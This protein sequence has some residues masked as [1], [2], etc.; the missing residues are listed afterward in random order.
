MADKRQH[1]A[2]PPQW[3]STPLPEAS[4]HQYPTEFKEQNVEGAG[5]ARN[6]N[7]YPYRGSEAGD[8]REEQQHQASY[9]GTKENGI[10]GELTA[11]QTAEEVSAR[12]VQ[13]VTAEA[14]AVLKGEQE[15]GSVPRAQPKELPLAEDSAN[16]PPSPPPSPAS[17]Q[18]GLVEE[19]K[20]VEDTVG[21]L[22][23]CPSSEPATN[24]ERRKLLAPSISVS[25][26][27][28]DPYN[29]DDEYY[30]HPLFSSEWTDSSTLPSTTAQRAD[31]LL[32]PDEVEETVEVPGVQEEKPTAL[33]EKEQSEDYGSAKPLEK[34]GGLSKVQVDH[35]LEALSH[36]E[37][38]PT[39]APNT[40]GVEVGEK[41]SLEET[42]PSASSGD[43]LA[44]E[45]MDVKDQLEMGTYSSLLSTG[46]PLDQRELE[47][48]LTEAPKQD[49]SASRIAEKE[50]VKKGSAP[51]E[52]T[53]KPQ[54]DSDKDLEPFLKSVPP[55]DQLDHMEE[56][57]TSV[58]E[59]TKFDESASPPKI[60]HESSVPIKTVT[61]QPLASERSSTV[62]KD[63]KK[64]PQTTLAAGISKAGTQQDERPFIS[65]I[66]II[67]E[68]QDVNI[69]SVSQSRS[70]AG[71][72]PQPKEV[73]KV[74]EKMQGSTEAPVTKD[75]IVDAKTDITVCTSPISE[76]KD[77][78]AKKDIVVKQDEIALSETVQQSVDIQSAKETDS[79]PVLPAK[80]EKNGSA[81]EK[82]EEG[83][84]SCS[85]GQKTELVEE[86]THYAKHESQMH[87]IADAETVQESTS[88]HRGT[89]YTEKGPAKVEVQEFK[90][91]T[92]MT[93]LAT[94]SLNGKISNDCLPA[95]TKQEPHDEIQVSKTQGEILGTE[96]K[97]KEKE[98]TQEVSIVK[99]VTEKGSGSEK[100]T[101]VESC[102]VE[103]VE[104]LAQEERGDK[105]GMSAYF[106]TTVLKESVTKSDVQQGS[107]YYELSN[108]KETTHEPCQAISVSSDED[109]Q[110][111]PSKDDV[112]IVTS[113]E[114]NYST[115]V[116]TFVSEEIKAPVTSAEYTLPSICHQKKDMQIHSKNKDDSH[117][118]LGRSLGLGGRSAIEQRSM[119]I[120]L[121]AS[122]LDSL[123][124]GLGR[125]HVTAL[126][127]LDPDSLTFTGGSVDETA[128]Y[129]PVT[130]PSVEMPPC[131]PIDVKQDETA[132]DV[133]K[134]P[135]QS[136]STG[137]PCESPFLAKD[138]YRNGTIVVPDLPEMLD[139]AGTRSRLASVSTDTD[140]AR[141]K[142]VPTS[143]DVT[144]TKP[145]LTDSSQ[146]VTEKES[147]TEDIGYCVFN[148]YAPAIPVPE[149]VKSPV[150]GD[151]DTTH[152]T[153]ATH[154]SSNK[155]LEKGKKDGPDD[156]ES[157]TEAHTE[158]EKETQKTMDT[159]TV[160]SQKIIDPLQS[161]V[162]ELEKDKVPNTQF[163]MEIK[164]NGASEKEQVKTKET[165]PQECT[166]GEV[167]L[168]VTI[169][170]TSD[171]TKKEETTK[172]KEVESE[173]Q[174]KQDSLHI[175]GEKQID[176]GTVETSLTEKI[177]PQQVT[178]I[179]SVTDKEAPEGKLDLRHHDLDSKHDI[180]VK[181]VKQAS[182]SKVRP[183]E[184]ITL[185]SI[186]K[187][188]DLSTVAG[189][190]APD[191][192]QVAKETDMVPCFEKELQKVTEE[193]SSELEPTGVKEIVKQSE[194][195]MK[196][197]TAKPDLVHQEAVDKEESYESSGEHEH[198]QE[199]LEV[200][201]DDA[202]SEEVAKEIKEQTLELTSKVDQKVLTDVISEKDNE[203]EEI[204]SELFGDAAVT[205]E[206]SLQKDS[207]L[208]SETVVT[209]EVTGPQ[210]ERDSV[211]LSEAVVV[212]EIAALEEHRI[213]ERDTQESPVDYVAESDHK[214][215]EPPSLFPPSKDDIQ[216]ESCEKP[217]EVNH[218]AEETEESPEAVTKPVEGAELLTAPAL[219]EFAEEAQPKQEVHKTDKETEQVLDTAV[220]ME[221]ET[222]ILSEKK[223]EEDI[224]EKACAP[225]GVVE[226]IVTIEDD[227]ITV[228]QTAVDEGVSHSIRFATPRDS[229]DDEGVH[230]PEEQADEAEETDVQAEPEKMPSE[231]PME[232]EETQVV[233][234]R[235]QT[236]DDYKDETTIDD[237]IMD[238][239]SLWVDTQDD[240]RSIMT[241]QLETI[242]K[243]ETPKKEIRRPSLDKHK[244]EKALKSGRDKISTPERK[245]AK[246]EPSTVSKDETRRKKAVY[247][248]AELGKKSEIQTHSPS[249]KIILK[250]AVRYPRPAHHS[251]AKRK[252]TAVDGAPRQTPSAVTAAKDKIAT[253]PSLTKIPTSKARAACV[254]P[255][256]PSS[257]CFV[258]KKAPSPDAEFYAVEPSNAGPRDDMIIEQC[259]KKDGTTRS[260]EKRSSLPRP[261]SILTSR[262]A[263]PTERDENSISMS[264]SSSSAPKRPTWTESSR[265]RTAKSGTST[266]TTPGSTAITPS[267]PPSYSSRTPG[268][269]GTP[270]YSRTPRTPGTPK[271]SILV[272]TEKKVAIIRTPPKSPATPKQLKVINQPLP[273]L[274]NIRS[275][276]GSIENIKYQP[277]GGQVQIVTKKIDLSHITSKCGSLSNIHHRPGG[278]NVKIE[279]VKLDFKEKAHAKVGSLDNAHHTPGGG[280]IKIESQKLSFR[281]QAKARVDHGAEIVT[282]SPNRSSVASPRRLS[283]VSSSGSIN[284]LESP[285]LATLA[286][287]VTA[288]LAK[289][290]L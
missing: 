288:A 56:A 205:K 67:Y 183:S 186:E 76:T 210:M 91:D 72:A 231:A 129:L 189:P 196:E 77:E 12:I 256:R 98:L 239:D 113:L 100:K 182:P 63:E 173:V 11:G 177:M 277:K 43:L 209:K 26:P 81:A 262:R 152:Q 117:L 278:G 144:H 214:L 243:E 139:L 252:Q 126:S 284:L 281:E 251:S 124:L 74:E 69:N 151:K 253:S 261:S 153:S 103:K 149:E 27:D 128:D 167:M 90:K 181:E 164:Y 246:K 227:F 54:H 97:I 94:G 105:S 80:V 86:T 110:I 51:A 35:S 188:T 121:P 6:E 15:K 62:K 266:P 222:H 48:K 180:A 136:V 194:S 140:I 118:Y 21:P 264:T 198:I 247:K 39:E 158:E 232:K 102:T 119:S 283:N 157:K 229:D 219:T 143:E 190:A 70:A 16:L 154:I 133:A 141:R 174:L 234:D 237:S 24:R 245:I 172:D 64:V 1:E 276:I 18:T 250:P 130:T 125:S 7:G 79:V 220:G 78:I 73:D 201:I 17:E 138:Y 28:D 99:G 193:K 84:V 10:N 88:T 223:F 254:L 202:R 25:V 93:Q 242:T 13:E 66:P 22:H 83:G 89:D 212:E 215:R 195:E 127:P 176:K 19:D 116:Q 59:T 61:I 9:R 104:H 131:F 68:A 115:L 255:T 137:S 114:E 50:A 107:D 36:E 286:E 32:S 111:K 82:S 270:S 204:A 34:A 272:P 45:K 290:G 44:A 225:A 123:T 29:S 269:P 217:A 53:T 101:E 132:T 8:C 248:K 150:Q 221:A 38:V 87:D 20:G 37:S 230:V 65:S 233:E 85:K 211:L 148:K 175:A 192:R 108:T 170:T 285:Q 280:N 2:S 208:P 235:T 33:I 249:R 279:S 197:K 171:V 159:T 207:E 218:L 257:A 203:P 41:T 178:A 206:H 244:K 259:R 289:Q 200:S 120:N 112:D 40:K 135:D 287:D 163:E 57:T 5:I 241:E 282:Q 23:R 106:E 55:K 213:L 240:D 122:C 75:D 162:T 226:S 47:H 96:S 179:S 268:T 165:T 160:L 265:S 52:E 156:T 263:Q 169:L 134:S 166:K 185:N 168:P 216:L 155:D 228:V 184:S 4:S 258:S 199:S 95:S 71:K 46:G 30:E 260:P 273:D 161:T 236:Y 3:S 142:S 49:S 92:P 267:T 238:T 271:S 14:V 275:K 224:T 191:T 274:K 145:P 31:A 42:I 109:K 187:T 147:L 60:V 146:I 58:K